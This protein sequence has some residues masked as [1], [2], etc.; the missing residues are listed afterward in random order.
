MFIFDEDGTSR[1]FV[2][3]SVARMELFK[4]RRYRVDK[5]T[6]CMTDLIGEVLAY[7]MFKHLSID[8]WVISLYRRMG[9]AFLDRASAWRCSTQDD[10]QAAHDARQML[11]FDDY[12]EK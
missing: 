9:Y 10:D 8:E 11:A 6:L 12:V 5:D 4:E 1:W 2:R 3:L 7:S